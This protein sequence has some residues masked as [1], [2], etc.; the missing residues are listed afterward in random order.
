MDN[1]LNVALVG[2]TSL[3]GETLLE[4]LAERDWPIAELFLLDDAEG[5]GQTL[6]FGGRN[7]RV[8]EAAG[9]D[10]AQARLVFCAGSGALTRSCLARARAAG[11]ALIDLSSSLLPDEAPR[12]VP[13]V[14]ASRL[15]E[16]PRPLLLSCPASPVTLLAC[17]LG[18]LRRLA[19]I[20]QVWLAAQLAV[21]H[22][23]REAV[24]ELAR[25]TAELLNARPLEPRLFDR[26]IAFN[27]LPQVGALD[28]EGH[29]LLERRIAS[30]LREVLELPGLAVGCHCQLA[31]VFFGDGLAVSLRLQSQVALEDVRALLEAE[32]ALE[33]LEDDYPTPV[34]DAVGQDAI[35]VGR[36]RQGQGDSRELDLWITS[37]NVRKG[38]ALNAVQMGELLIKHYL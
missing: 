15:A 33:L 5:A 21:S 23:G 28:A 17:V 24:T 37:D 38:A 35:Y 6:A 22:L 9:F 36:L 18:P 27:L 12:I 2:A 29:A 1:K 31:P 11:C 20:E 16:L 25:Q 4:L 34:G 30:E 14:N 3:V 8:R 7:L 26:Q 10:F 19:S 13:E 32:A